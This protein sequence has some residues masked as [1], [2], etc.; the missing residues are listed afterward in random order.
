MVHGQKR[1]RNTGLDSFSERLFGKKRGALMTPLQK[2]WC[3]D[4]AAAEYFSCKEPIAFMF[5]HI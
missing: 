4:D 3:F 2:T 5:F 1:L